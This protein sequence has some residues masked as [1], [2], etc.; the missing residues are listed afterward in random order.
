MPSEL[1]TRSIV[2]PAPLCDLRVVRAAPLTVSV[3]PVPHSHRV[4]T[5]SVVLLPWVT[6]TCDVGLPGPRLPHH[7]PGSLWSARWGW[8]Y[9]ARGRA[10]HNHIPRCLDRLDQPALGT[11]QGDLG[12]E[13]V[14]R[15]EGAVDAGEPEV[16]HLVEFAQRRQDG[17][18]HLVGGHLGPSLGAQRV[19]DL[20]AEASQVVLGDR[21]A[22]AGLPDSRDR[23]VPGERLGCAGSL[24]DHELH[25][26]DGG[27][28]LAALAA[29]A[30]ATDRSAVLGDSAVEH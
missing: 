30:A 24:H 10:R 7:G 4:T 20:L 9:G 15:L 27:E 29:R 16:R 21:T 25:L 3:M 17:H 8:L 2:R 13:V 12:L 28:A 23:L 14:G 18:T 22:L 6:A 26:L 11:Q 5:L 1:K 19:L